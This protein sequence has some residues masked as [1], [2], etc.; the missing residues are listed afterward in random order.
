MGNDEEKEEQEEGAERE[1][2][3]RQE[4]CKVD[5]VAKEEKRHLWHGPKAVW[6]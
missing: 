4:G 2:T 5:H 6:G 1:A 3:D